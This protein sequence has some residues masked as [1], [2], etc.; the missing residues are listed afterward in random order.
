VN[1]PYDRRCRETQAADVIGDGDGDDDGACMPAVGCLAACCIIQV[2]F[3]KGRTAFGSSG[4]ESGF[5]L[6]AWAA[7]VQ[8]M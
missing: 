7:Y 1:Y 5:A 8:C 4:S 3:E 2:V 6:R